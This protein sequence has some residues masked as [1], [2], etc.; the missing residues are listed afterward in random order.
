MIGSGCGCFF[1]TVS[2][3]TRS[4]GNPSLPLRLFRWE[5]TRPAHKRL[6]IFAAR[7]ATM[8]AIR[9]HTRW[10][11]RS[12]RVSAQ[13]GGISPPTDGNNSTRAGGES[14][15]PAGLTFRRLLLGQMMDAPPRVE[16]GRAH[17]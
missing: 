3:W 17:Q 7:F 12:M 11:E 9:L 14:S 10:E 8:L 4:S 1:A 16:T 13:I 5:R 6:L 2:G 15:P